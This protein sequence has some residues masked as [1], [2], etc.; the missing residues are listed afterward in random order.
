MIFKF[1]INYKNKQ[2]VWLFLF[3]IWNF[4]REMSLVFQ[5]INIVFV[6]RTLR[7]LCMKCV[8]FCVIN[9]KP[10]DFIRGAPTLSRNDKQLISQKNFKPV[11]LSQECKNSWQKSFTQDN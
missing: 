11:S 10:L 8:K 2:K 9:K 5:N 4:T 7:Q 1:D 3:V 6:G